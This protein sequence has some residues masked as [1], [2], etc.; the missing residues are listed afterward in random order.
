MRVLLGP[1]SNNSAMLVDD[2]SARSAGS[3][4]NPKK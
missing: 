2:Q 4:I 1:G 3:N